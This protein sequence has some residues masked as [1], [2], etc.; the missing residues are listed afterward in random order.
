M[1]YSLQHCGYNCTIIKRY[2]ERTDFNSNQMN[3]K[4]PAKSK[5]DTDK[6]KPKLMK[7][8][9]RFKRTLDLQAGF[10]PQF[11]ALNLKNKNLTNVQKFWLLKGA[12]G[13]KHALKK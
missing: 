3:L 5:S 10:E 2:Q 11:N 8:K 4:S 1:Q 6:D 9:R 12:M 13:K 7:K